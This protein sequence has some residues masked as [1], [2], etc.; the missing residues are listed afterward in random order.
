MNE[1]GKEGRKGKRKKKGKEEGRK[2]KK[3]L[4]GQMSATERTEHD[5]FH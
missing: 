4:T 2:I 3:I 5:R 1:G